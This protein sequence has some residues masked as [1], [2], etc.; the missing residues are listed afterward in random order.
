MHLCQHHII[1]I[2]SISTFPILAY[3]VRKFASKRPTLISHF[4]VRTHRSAVFSFVAFFL[5]QGTW[6]GVIFQ[7][8]IFVFVSV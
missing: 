4:C 3:H 2:T 7:S 8:Y 5:H 1:P 6:K